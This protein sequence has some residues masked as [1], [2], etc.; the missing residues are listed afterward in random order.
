MYED[1]SAYTSREKAGSGYNY[2]LLP[3]IKNFSF[4]EFIYNAL[5]NN[6][7]SDDYG[8]FLV[9][10]N[11]QYIIGY[12]SELGR[13]THISS[14]ARTM[15][16]LNGGGRIDR[17]SD[18]LK[19]NRECR[20]NFLTARVLYECNSQTENGRNMYSGCIDFSLGTQMI[21]KDQFEVFKKFYE[22]Y[23]KEIEI[24]IKKCSLKNFCVWLS[25][26]D[27]NG[28]LCVDKSGNLDNLYKYLENHID[29]NKELEDDKIILGVEVPKTS[30]KKY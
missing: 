25:Y 11:N 19:L 28:K 13:G 30:K 4:L 24:V 10:T 8:A 1:V 20:N 2:D 9:I 16:N 3:L 15:K 27:E 5:K 6:E 29:E 17:D 23:N 12:N 18:A 26:R 21:T 22:D 7:N 14:F